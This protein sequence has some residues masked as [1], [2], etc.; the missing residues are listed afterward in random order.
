MKANA[1]RFSIA[2]VI[3]LGFI[4]SVIDGSVYAQ[5]NP[6]ISTMRTR[7]IGKRRTIALPENEFRI[8]LTVAKNP[9]ETIALSVKALEG[10]EEAVWI[11][12]NNNNRKDRGEEV[13]RFG[14]NRESYTVDAQNVTVYGKVTVLNCSGNGLTGLTISAFSFLEKLDCSSNRIAVLDVNRC[15]LL[16]E[17]ICDGNRISSL[18]IGKMKA[19]ERISCSG[20]ELT[21]LDVK[22]TNRLERI[23]CAGNN[24][25]GK[26][27][28][29]LLK[30]LP[31]RNGRL[32]GEITVSESLTDEQ[33]NIASRKNWETT[34]LK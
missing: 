20:N 24:I 9:G 22:K 15:N 13:T 7:Q 16:K 8:V 32:P 11:D 26:Q 27:M 17:L 28:T 5:E 19:L 23:S 2:G 14:D 6:D 33:K 25:A 3:A 4:V 29:A 1:K 31:D 21:S 12:L 18:K 10:Y 30:S 34:T